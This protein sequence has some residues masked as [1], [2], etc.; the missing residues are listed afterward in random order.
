VGQ[1]NGRVHYR[2][3]GHSYLLGIAERGETLIESHLAAKKHRP[4]CMVTKQQ[5]PSRCLITTARIHQKIATLRQARQM[6]VAN[7]HQ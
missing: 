2:Q 6:R 4:Q 7:I 5:H 1:G 3:S